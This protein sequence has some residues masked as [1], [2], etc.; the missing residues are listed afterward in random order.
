[1]NR[2]IKFLKQQF[3]PT[4]IELS[5]P[6]AF[7]ILCHSNIGLLEVLLSTTFRPHNSY[8]IYVDTKASSSFKKSVNDL[9]AIYRE[10][11][12]KTTLILANPTR[13]IFWSDVSILEAGNC[14][15]NE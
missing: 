9:L 3:Q 11:F 12:P 2:I 6:L 7:S 13:R 10:K 1:L 15:C 14:M 8:C 4:D 5:T